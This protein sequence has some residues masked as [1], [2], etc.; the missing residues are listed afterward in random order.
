[1]R[2]ITIN[3]TKV[4]NTDQMNFPVLI[5]LPPNTYPDLKTTAN[6]GSVTNANGYD[7][8]FTSGRRWDSS[9]GLAN[10]KATTA[11]PVR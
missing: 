7:I 8:L 2:T 11:L 3:D 9:S 1:M 5:S 4:P 10:G 6:G